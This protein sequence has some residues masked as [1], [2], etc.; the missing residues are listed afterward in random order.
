MYELFLTFRKCTHLQEV[1]LI[2][3][4]AISLFLEVGMHACMHVTNLRQVISK[5]LF[6]PYFKH[7]SLE[8]SWRV[9]SAIYSCWFNSMSQCFCVLILTNSG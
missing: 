7:Q 4:I 8:L 9:Q 6:P 1:N 3:V 5:L 2:F